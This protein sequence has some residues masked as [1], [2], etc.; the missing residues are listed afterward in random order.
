MQ[1]SISL[2]NPLV[3]VVKTVEREGW[4][5]PWEARGYRE[6]F[7]S[8]FRQGGVFDFSSWAVLEIAG[9]DAMGYLQRMSTVNFK[10]MTP[11]MVRHGAFLTGRGTVVTL[12]FFEQITADRYHYL[13]SPNQRD[14]ALE[15]IEKFHF[16]ES[17]TL[18]DKSEQW[19][20][21]GVWQPGEAKRGLPDLNSQE[22]PLK[23]RGY[24]FDGLSAEVWRDDVMINLWW[25]K[26]PPTLLARFFEFA[27][28]HSVDLL[29]ERLF[30]FLRLKAGIARVGQE[31][32]S[33]DLIL[34][35]NFERAVARNKGCYPGQEVV[36]RIFTYGQVNRKLL[37]VELSVEG[38]LP[39][40]P[41]AIEQD[42][43]SVGNLVSYDTFP[44][45][46]R[47]AYGLAYI[48]KKYWN[49]SGPWKLPAGTL[50][51]REAHGT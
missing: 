45:D 37:P 13:V 2:K 21:C 39:P 47:R 43:Q 28:K 1:I 12:G 25:I 27:A 10:E 16:S 8:A 31:L 41:F 24:S 17:F 33:T 23:A 32:S 26:M 48:Q 5:V 40:V 4:K 36:E 49:Q 7:D 38:Q 14:L 42:G 19:T 11:G 50:R 20:L 46:D 51:L 3:A 22:V 9:P 44:D 15:H 29:G 30:H 35:G 34:E 18:A 6:D